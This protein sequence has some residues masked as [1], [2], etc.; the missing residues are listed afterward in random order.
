MVH[1]LKWHDSQLLWDEVAKNKRLFVAEKVKWNGD[2][3]DPEESIQIMD[4]YLDFPA[5]T[6]NRNCRL[7]YRKGLGRIF[8]L[9]DEDKTELI[10]VD[11]LADSVVHDVSYHEI[12]NPPKHG[13]PDIKE[14][15]I[16]SVLVSGS[17]LKSSGINKNI[18]CLVHNSF[19]KY[20]KD[21]ENY[22]F[23]I[24]KVKNDEELEKELKKHKTQI[25]LCQDRYKL[26]IIF[27]IMSSNQWMLAG[28]DQEGAFQNIELNQDDDTE[29]ISRLNNQS[30]DKSEAIDE[31]GVM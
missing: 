18:H 8:G 30:D 31:T 19:Y 5:S 26:L 9:M 20:G 22:Y 28:L 25:A 15:A 14:L 4:G 29:L 21:L 16:G 13:D 1:M 2:K 11:S 3:S 6:H 23:S 17:T 7:L 12:Y 10:P 24:I 27:S